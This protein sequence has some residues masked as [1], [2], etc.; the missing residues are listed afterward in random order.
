MRVD[1]LSKHIATH[2]KYTLELVSS[3]AIHFRRLARWRGG[4]ARHPNLISGM[5]HRSRQWLSKSRSCNALQLRPSRFSPMK[6]LL[7]A[8]DIVVP[9]MTNFTLADDERSFRV[10]RRYH[11]FGAKDTHS[12]VCWPLRR[13]YIVSVRLDVT[14][15]R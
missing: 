1:K 13:H 7:R 9:A 10:V 3:E 4:M 8:E 2:K 11:T 14:S 6:I 12:S 15:L 5:H